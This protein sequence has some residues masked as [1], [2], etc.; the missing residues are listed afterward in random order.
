MRSRG[1]PSYHEGR[2][3]TGEHTGPEQK[4]AGELGTQI[5]VE[6][7]RGCRAS[8]ELGKGARECGILYGYFSGSTGSSLLEVALWLSVLE[9]KLTLYKGVGR[10]RIFCQ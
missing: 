6:W 5:L 9:L 4:A 10:L 1:N 2:A 3:E 8:K 7:E